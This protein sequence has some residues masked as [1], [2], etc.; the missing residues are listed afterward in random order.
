[1]EG[2]HEADQLMRRTSLY[3]WH[4]L[5][6]ILTGF[7]YLAPVGHQRIRSHHLGLGKAMF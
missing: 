7:M 1:M 5:L 6:S 3:F 4:R 2:A